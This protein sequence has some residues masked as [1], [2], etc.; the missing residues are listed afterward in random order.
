M[1]VNA[2]G[3]SIH[4]QI[5]GPPDGAVVVF[6]HALATDLAMWQ[7]QV[8]A[9]AS[10]FRTVRFD[11]RGHGQSS[12]SPGGYDFDTLADDTAALIQT[13]GLGKAYYVGLSMGGVVGMKL[14]LK[15]PQLV[16]GLVLSNTRSEVDE[17]FRR[18][19]AARIDAALNRGMASLVE[20][21]L[22]RWFP[23]HFVNGRAN[24]LA[25]IRAAFVNTS[26]EAYASY[27]ADL[28]KLDLTAQLSRLKLPALVV[29]GQ[30]DETT[31]P[32]TL[33]K[34]HGAIAGSTLTIIDDCA[35]FPNIE[36]PGLFNDALLDFL[37]P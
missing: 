35:H 34:I 3:I 27:C 14:A 37:Q 29:G 36:W 5:D 7:P 30:H 16:S 11:F 6:G 4:C 1:F 12:R 31:P 8:D 32:H 20:P 13:L 28:G 17:A 26:L 9:L 19:C 25:H 22:S 24:D 33:R 21:T 10:H 18:T 2:N 23:P 15:H